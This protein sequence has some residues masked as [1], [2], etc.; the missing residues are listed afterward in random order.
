MTL[1]ATTKAISE[2][3]INVAINVTDPSSCN[4]HPGCD[5][6]TKSTSL[7]QLLY[8]LN[9]IGCYYCNTQ[10]HQY[11]RLSVI[12]TLPL[13]VTFITENLMHNETEN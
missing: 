10:L 5:A 13:P 2:G 7:F 8:I 4:G 9:T 6:A 1:L 3:D 11:V 12:Q